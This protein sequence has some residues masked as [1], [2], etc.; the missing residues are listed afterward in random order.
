MKALRKGV[1]LLGDVRRRCQ[2]MLS[3]EGDTQVDFYND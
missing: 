1:G 2:E 3:R